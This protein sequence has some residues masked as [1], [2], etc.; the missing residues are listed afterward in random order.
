MKGFRDSRQNYDTQ[1]SVLP[2][3]LIAKASAR[4]LVTAL[5]A[6]MI[7]LSLANS[8]ALAQG[9]SPSEP[10]VH[11]PCRPRVASGRR[12]RGDADR[13]RVLGESKHA[14][15]VG[16]AFARESLLDCLLEERLQPV[17]L[18]SGDDVERM[19]HASLLTR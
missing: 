6:F 5:V 8:L 1:S 19:V 14:K 2:K 12:P 18:G 11:T 4:W 9:P 16:L 15:P 10:G 3:R 17:V 13:L 7:A